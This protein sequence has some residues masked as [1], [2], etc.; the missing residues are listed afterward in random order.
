MPDNRFFVEDKFSVNESIVIT[1]R[2]H[3]HLYRVMRKRVG[4]QIEII[5]G[6]GDLIEATLKEVD[7]ESA[8]LLIKKVEH[9]EPPKKT[10]RLIQGIPNIARLEVL[11]EKCTELGCSEFW[12]YFASKSERRLF[13]EQKIE[14][15]RY[16]VISALKQC[17]ALYLPRMIFFEE[18]DE[19]TPPE[20]PLFFGDLRPTAHKTTSS[21]ESCTFI[22]GPES[23]F[24]D[25]EISYFENK[26]DAKGI[27]L[28][29]NQLRTE[30][31][32]ITATAFFST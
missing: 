13:S 19:I 25:E 24:T 1:G 20:G 28:H 5:N 8:E 18:I 21:N 17:G 22:N 31:A 10:F 26:W 27:S 32:A 6:Q 2:E 7:D 16:I 12:L 30:T 4:E 11:L 3:Y 9:K 14:R 23:G 29:P 15:L